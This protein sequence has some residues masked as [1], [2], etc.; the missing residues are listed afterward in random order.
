[1]KKLKSELIKIEKTLYT[2]LG[3]IK[4]TEIVGLT[5]NCSKY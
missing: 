5:H 2:A 4:E 1:M 3:E